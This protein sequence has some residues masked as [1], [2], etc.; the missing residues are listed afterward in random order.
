VNKGGTGF[1]A[2]REPPTDCPGELECLSVSG[3][4]TRDATATVALNALRA[5]SGNNLT[6]CTQSVGLLVN[7]VPEGGEI[8][9]LGEG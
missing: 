8:A 7:L 2:R 3:V 9:G 4:D 1:L 5:F 6:L